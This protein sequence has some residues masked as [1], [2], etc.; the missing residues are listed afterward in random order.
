VYPPTQT[1]RWQRTTLALVGYDWG[2][3]PEAVRKA[4]LLDA[5]H[6]DL[7]AR[8]GAAQITLWEAY[9]DLKAAER[10]T[11]AAGADQ[12]RALDHAAA[13]RLKVIDFV[14]SY[15]YPVPSTKTRS[16]GANTGLPRESECVPRRLTVPIPLGSM[17]RDRMAQAKFVGNAIGQAAARDV[18]SN[19][20]PPYSSTRAR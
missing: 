7:V 11:E 1:E 19:P 4:R 12:M 3:S 17:P 9:R 16:R 8:V 2:V 13:E 18:L 10:Q 5:G 15:S 14:I 6:P 20:I